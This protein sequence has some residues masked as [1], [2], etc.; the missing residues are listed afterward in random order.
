MNEALNVDV[1]KYI[2]NKWQTEISER[3]SGSDK[4]KFVVGGTMWAIYDI[5]NKI[6]N[7]VEKRSKI[8]PS[9]KFRYVF[10]SEYGKAVF[11]KVPALDE[12][13]KSTCDAVHNTE[14]YINK[15]NDIDPVLF[16]CTYQQQ[17]LAP[18][19]LEFSYDKLKHY[20]ELPVN[21]DGS[22]ACTDYAFA[23]LDPA[24]K[25]KDFVSMPIFR[26][27]DENY[28][29]ID[30]LYQKKAMTELYDEIANRIIYHKTIKL[31][32][33]NNTDSSLKTVIDD[34]LKNKGY[35]NCEIIE[36][37]NTTKKEL[38][39]Q[40]NRWHIINF[41]FFKSRS[42]Y[43]SNSEYGQ[44]M[45]WLTSYSFDYP[46]KHDDAPDSLAMF[47]SEII[48]GKGRPPKPK[49]ISRDELGF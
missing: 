4:A 2:Y 39:I 19:G 14:Y 5:L 40:E 6:Y 46:N 27:N 29:L 3:N 20:D 23:V 10:E 24:R 18:T 38:R 42:L 32:V 28:Y 34:K 1:H 43:S 17:P 26:R 9:K 12:N 21:N 37:Y 49:A 31:V 47:C 41:I 22:S 8:I 25:G 33:E 7:D 30:V 36:K 45:S 13:D 16:S 11:I 48:R 35:F 44:F 15:R